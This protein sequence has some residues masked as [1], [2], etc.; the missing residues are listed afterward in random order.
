MNS[1]KK[2]NKLFARV[3]AFHCTGQRYLQTVE[4]SLKFFQQFSCDF[5]RIASDGLISNKS[6]C[7][8][9]VFAIK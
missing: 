8:L 2:I 7:H 9:M 4:F 5:L 3:K 6:P 1:F